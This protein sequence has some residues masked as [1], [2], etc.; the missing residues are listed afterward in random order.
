MPHSSAPD[1]TAA[2]R[3][4]TRVAPTDRLAWLAAWAVVTGLML[5]PALWNGF[6]L[7]YADT[8]GYLMRPVTGTLSIG[9][10][11]LYGSFLL[12]GM[13]LDFWPVVIVQAGIT[14]WLIV[15][16]MRLIAGA[17]PLAAVLVGLALA[18]L[19]ALP[20][21]AAQ[22]MPD[23]MAG[24][25]V[26]ALVLLVVRPDA[27]PRWQAVLLAAVVAVA[28]AAHMGTLALCIGL[29]G[30]VTAYGVAAHLVRRTVPLPRP[31]L[32]TAAAA[33]AAGLLLAPLSNLALTGHFAFTPGGS[34]FLFGRL[35]Q[36]GIVGRYLDQHCP[37]PAIS[38]C[39]YRDKLPAT[40]DE[41]LWTHASPLYRLGNWQGYGDESARIA[42]ATLRLYPLDHLAAAA[43]ATA[44]QLV[45]FRTTLAVS[46]GDNADALDA[47][48]RLLPPDALARF[49]DARQQR[50]KPD[51]AA[52]NLVHVPAAV[53]A[54][55]VTLYGIAGGRRRVP[56]P[57]RL[58]C[59]AVLLALLG[60]AAVCGVF[61]NPNDRYQSRLIWL[62]VLAAG[63]M[64]SARPRESGDPDANPGFPLARE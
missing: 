8:G 28:I 26:L 14:A 38:L 1:R 27:L 2:D 42:A 55:M 22:L 30:C 31:K 15:T 44:G 39:P 6:P 36:D 18:I 40:A 50:E 32:G 34:S 46:P 52:L 5:W 47:L 59:G 10:S 43:R 19:T 16:V 33:V 60:N 9:R 53:L 51:V 29:L 17:R 11:A 58:L 13:P 20:W 49:H 64:L 25:A 62:A 41:W 4:A 24:W 45:L 54:V 63:V 3:A 48:G 37:D 57:T 56:V 23:V 7:I 12:A 35:V 61:S 21:Y